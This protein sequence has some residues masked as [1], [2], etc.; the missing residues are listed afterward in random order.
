MGGGGMRLSGF[1]AEVALGYVSHLVWN[2][3]NSGA[4]KEQPR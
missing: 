1:W 2:S 4:S 3:L